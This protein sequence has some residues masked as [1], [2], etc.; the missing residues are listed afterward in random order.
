MM[1]QQT[2]L[3]EI[4]TE[5]LPPKGLRSLA[6]SFATNFTIEM[7]NANLTHGLVTWFATPRRLALKVC[8]LSAS[9]PDLIVKKRGP[10]IKEAFHATGRPKKAAERWARSCGISVDQAERIVTGKGAWLMYHNHV[11]GEVVEKLLTGI[12]SSALSKLSI[13]KLMRWGNFKEPFV[14]PVHTVTLLL[15]RTLIPGKILGIESARI[16][17]GNRFMGETEFAL[18]SADHYPQILKKR[19]KVIADYEERKAIIK[20]SAELAS[21]KIGGKADLSDSLLEEVASLVEW[22]V[23]L[24]AQFEEAFLSVPEEALVH[25]MKYDQKYFPVYNSKGNLL[26]HFIFVANIESKDPKKI[27]SGNEK[28]VHSR[29]SDAKFFFDTDRKKNLEDYLPRLKTVIFHKDLGTLYDKTHRIKALSVWI[30]SQINADV[31]SASRAAM[32]SKC[33]LVTSMVCEFS[34]TQGAMGMHYA[35]HDNEKEEVAIALNDQ[36]HPRFSGDRLPRS[37]VACSLAI[38]DKMDTLTGIFIIRKNPK[39]DQDP[40]GLRRAALGVLRI[41]VEK[42][43]PLDLQTL[44]EKTVQ[45]YGIELNNNKVVDEIVTFM[46]GRFPAWYQERGYETDTIRS[47]LA[48]RPTRPVD[49]HARIK[50][51]SHFS[52]LKISSELSEANK[53]VSNILAKSKDTP[54][55]RVR[56][57]VLKEASEIQLA[58]QIT[59]LGDEVERCLSS[60]DYRGALMEL[61]A[62]IKPI[63]NFFKS[64]IVMSEDDSVRVNRITLLSKLSELFLK[65]AD[66]SLL[67]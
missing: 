2:F 59:V 28:V 48:R 60:E 65:V 39:C 23:V 52:N 4:G 22:P 35:R 44:T 50:A 53:R 32:L 38:A 33:D 66:I 20:H 57:S 67:Q 34:D 58:R 8:N 9:Q 15:G 10:S 1:T 61:T 54:N 16:I 29:F 26:P 46:L 11:K 56:D 5:E 12:V 36:Y 30:A 25:T 55:A 18:D 64:V 51:V 7:K 24:T 47:V 14:R 41:I 45:L 31:N 43:L 3:V 49:F 27:I 63:D 62:L 21:E 42:T 19:G 40:F 17:R 13:P 6:T 37:R